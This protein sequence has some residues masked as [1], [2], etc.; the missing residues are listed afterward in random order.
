MPGGAAASLQVE[1]SY[2]FMD[3]T[4]LHRHA[5]HWLRNRGPE[6]DVAISSRVRLARNLVGHP[7]PTRATERQKDEVRE[8]LERTLHEIRPGKQDVWVH[9]NDA[10]DV[11]REV[12]RERHLISREHAEGDRHGRAVIFSKGEILSVM[13]NEEDHLRMQ[14]VRAGFQLERAY[15]VIDLLDDKVGSKVEYAFNDRFGYLTSCPTNTGTALRAGVMLH[16]PALM[17]QRHVEKVMQAAQK[18][19][20]VVRGAYGEGSKPHGQFFQISNQVTLGKSEDQLIHDLARLARKVIE[21]ERQMRKVL[22]A[23][24]R[25]KTEDRILR[26]HGILKSARI[27]TTEEAMGH[28]SDLRLGIV[29]GLIKDVPLESV[30]ELFVLIQPAHLQRM[31]GMEI[32]SEERNRH[33]AEF[34]RN[35][36]AQA[37]EDTGGRT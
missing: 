1:L 2:R 22:L 4:H 12:L 20:M 17:V 29:L 5:G 11:D 34:I 24:Q 26:S 9:L 27:F 7:F 23:E 33:R 16:L 25:G 19:G 35:R 3:L 36:L 6:A 21:Y 8:F 15:R 37:A 14:V 10:T 30:N 32:G 18:M 13:I 31:L 28:L